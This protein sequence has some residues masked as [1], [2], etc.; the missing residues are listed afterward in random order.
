[1]KD[2]KI[3]IIDYIKNY[4]AAAKSKGV[5]VGMSGGKDSF[6][7]AKL[8]CEAI[9]KD[10][11]FGLIMPNG[12]MTDLDDAIKEC[13]L[14][15]IKYKIAD[16]S[17]AYNDTVKLT[18]EVLETEELSSVSLLNIAPR[19]RMNLLYSVGGTLGYLVANT[20][21]L[22]ERMIGYSTKWGD[23]VG[24]F[25]PLANLTK[26]EVCEL[27]IELGLPENLVNKQPADGLT[28]S[29]DEDKLGFLYSELDDF[30]RNGKISANHKK[31]M[32]A[33]NSTKHKRMEISSFNPNRKNNFSAL[34]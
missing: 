8:A 34:K 4:V 9:G 33:H 10:S 21:N 26:T 12:K 27:G 30:I 28:G 31:I 2:L 16:I 29:T 18:K 15:Q 7:V 24:D 25:A 6:V 11:V 13:E 1:M 19:L 5:I 14:L 32:S 3:E 23:A 20:S 22:S 17:A